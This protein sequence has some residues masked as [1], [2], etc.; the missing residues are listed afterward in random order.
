M[1]GDTNEPYPPYK[2]E[3]ILAL[4]DEVEKTGRMLSA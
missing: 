2:R 4:I 1:V 3:N